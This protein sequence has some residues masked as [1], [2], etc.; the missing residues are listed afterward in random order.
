V[1]SKLALG[2]ALALAAAGVG[3]DAPAAGRKATQPREFVLVLRPDVAQCPTGALPRVSVVEVAADPVRFKGACV[4]LQGV[5]AGDGLYADLDAYQRRA[6]AFGPYED[7][8]KA[9]AGGVGVYAPPDLIARKAAAYDMPVRADMVGKLG[10]CEDL[11]KGALMVSGYCRG[12]AG[13]ILAVDDADLAP[14]RVSRLV[15]EDDRRKFGNLA[16]APA[17]W[18]AAAQV[19][20]LLAAWLQAVAH[21]DADT[22]A[23][24]HGK[25]DSLKGARPDEVMRAVEIDEGLWSEVRSWSRPHQ[26]AVFVAKP[27]GA[28]GPDRS[29]S[30]WDQAAVGC[31]CREDDCAGRWPISYAD[32]GTNG[33]RP[34]LCVEL[35]RSGKDRAS[36]SPWRVSAHADD[37]RLSEPGG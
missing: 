14:L 26:T 13:A 6:T 11:A 29:N 25:G 2:L 15:S 9:A 36:P 35:R 28:S 10:T 5:W 34:Y 30:R 4:R 1:K 21:G 3:T 31:V 27:R 17:D 8:P 24:L 23:R 37:R 20:G 33:A 19:D 12:G 18:A 22:L 16:P 7:E 32:T